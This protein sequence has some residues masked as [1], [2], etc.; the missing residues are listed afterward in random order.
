MDSAK[1]QS[2]AGQETRILYIFLYIYIYIRLRYYFPETL[3]IEKFEEDCKKFKELSKDRKTEFDELKIS[4]KEN[5]L[6]EYK[7]DEDFEKKLKDLGNDAD[8]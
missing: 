4:L 2:I 3:D 6:K 1:D 7:L 8:I 5:K